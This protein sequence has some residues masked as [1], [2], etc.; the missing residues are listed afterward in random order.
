MYTTGTD[1]IEGHVS[2]IGDIITSRKN[3]AN[4]IHLKYVDILSLA[5][6]IN[7][8][9]LVLAPGRQQ[10]VTLHVRTLLMCFSS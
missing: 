1:S 7:L 8:Q 10:S 5:E 3:S 9:E 6:S 2:N 4:L